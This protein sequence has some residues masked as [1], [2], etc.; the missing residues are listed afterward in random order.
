MKTTKNRILQH[1]HH[2]HGQLIDLVTAMLV[3]IEEYDIKVV[4]LEKTSLFLFFSLLRLHKYYHV[5]FLSHR[6]IED[7][8]DFQNR[9]TCTK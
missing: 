9:C 3:E 8:R 4:H 5:F 1:E 7:V 6:L 2:K